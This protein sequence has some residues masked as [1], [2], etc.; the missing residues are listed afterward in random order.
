MGEAKR[1]RKWRET[2]SDAELYDDMNRRLLPQIR[3]EFE[4]LCVQTGDPEIATL[5]MQAATYTLPRGC[6]YPEQL[7][8]ENERDYW[9]R[10]VNTL[11]AGFAEWQELRDDPSEAARQRRLRLPFQA[12][13]LTVSGG[14]ELGPNNPNILVHQAVSMEPRGD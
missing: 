2:A 1:R 3:A 5:I 11:A 14:T 13:T 8:Y 4:R 9:T 6:E 10:V 7:D 12:M